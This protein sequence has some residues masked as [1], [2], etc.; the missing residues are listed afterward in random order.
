MGKEN[1]MK[2]RLI[3]LFILIGLVPLLVASILSYVQ[4]RRVM[5]E[6]IKTAGKS[7][8]QQ[9]G[10]QLQTIRDLNR[11]RIEDYFD[12]TVK[13]CLLSWRGPRH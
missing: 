5:R 9:V 8:E 12:A 1:A 11:Q 4:G 6:V 7:M 2:K 3:T 10:T 13:H